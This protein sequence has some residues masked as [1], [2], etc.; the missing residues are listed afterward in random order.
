MD[1]ANTAE[2]ERPSAKT[3]AA[4]VSSEVM[5]R[6][7]VVLATRKAGSWAP[8]RLHF[9]VPSARR[10][11]PEVARHFGQ[12]TARSLPMLEVFDLLRRFAQT[13][14]T[15]ALFGETGVGKDVVAHA[16]HDQSARSGGPF[17]VFDCG[18]VAASLA[19]SELLGHERGAFTGAVSAHA[20]VF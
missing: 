12:L 13:D 20:G 7:P 19:E 3:R 11:Q 4:A 9:P 5:T 6:E 14:V 2:S 10:R 17:V 15:V 1:V 8:P 16:L 18:A